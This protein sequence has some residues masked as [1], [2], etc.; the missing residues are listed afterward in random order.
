MKG[1]A[2]F[3]N[4][5]YQSVLDEILAVQ[6]V[7]PEQIM[8]LQPYKSQAIVRLRDVP[9]SVDDPMRLLI[10]LTSDLPTVR[11]AAEIVG[12]DDKRRLPGTPRHRVLNRLIC[13]LQPNE[14]GLYNLSTAEDGESVNLLHVRRLRPLRAPFSVTQLTKTEGGPV[15]DQRTTS[16]GWAYI[17]TAGLP[18]LLG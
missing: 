8:F 15:S 6:S 7:L 9:P 5:V 14:G 12:W 1:E 13:T 2:L 18:E 16:G 17:Q 11:Y 4:G 3:L 10:S